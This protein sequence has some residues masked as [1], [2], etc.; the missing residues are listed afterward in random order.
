VAR[1]T[2]LPGDEYRLLSEKFDEM[3]RKYQDITQKIRYLERKNQVVMQKNKDMKESVRAWQEY[4]DRTSGKIKSR[5]DTAAKDRF[6]RPMTAPQVDD[7]RPTVSHSPVSAD[8]EQL[9]HPPTDVGGSSPSPV[10][11]PA[12]TGAGNSRRSKLPETPSNNSR[13]SSSGSITPKPASTTERTN[14]HAS[15]SSHV[16]PFSRTAIYLE[17]EHRAHSESYGAPPTSSQ[18]TVDE[19]PE[20]PTHTGGIDDDDD[21]PQFVS[22][23]SLKRKRGPSSKFAIYTDRSADGTP[24]KPVRVKDEPP[25][26]PPCAA[27]TL[28]RKETIDLDEP[29][30][31]LLLTPRHRKSGLSIHSNSTGISRHQRSN[32]APFSQ[33]L[34]NE[35]YQDFQRPPDGLSYIQTRLQTAADLRA[36]SEP[37]DPSL[38]STDILRVIDSNIILDSTEEVSSKRQKQGSSRRHSKHATLAESGNESPMDENRTR[39]SSNPARARFNQRQRA[40]KNPQT[41]AKMLHPTSTSAPAKIKLEQMPTPPSSSRPTYTPSRGSGLRSGM[42]HAC[43]NPPDEPATDNR[44]TWSM[45]APEKRTNPRRELAA[46]SERQTPLRT[47]PLQELRIQDFRPNPAFNQGYSYAFSET[48]RK[49][50]DRMCLPGCTNAQCCG[51]TFRVLAEAQAPLPPSQEEALLEDYLGDAYDHMVS[52]QMAAEERAELVLQARTKKMAKENGKH[53]EAYERRRT[54]PGFWR[55]DFPTTQEQVE[56]R[57]RAKELE[58]KAVEERW[59]DAQRKGGRWIFR[60]E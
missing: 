7:N 54:P 59:L 2:T 45:K 58:A 52:T 42:S 20:Q 14:S 32:S 56:D 12:D 49:R 36:F 55:V 40:A 57:A 51:S 37:F 9:P 6:S 5:G 28:L 31:N 41:P 13:P 30:P 22:E 18:T 26:S 19:H 8:T 23:H 46:S 11:L 44:P 15:G 60:D 1:A 10:A 29:A 4:A 25:S 35:D 38:S 3:K 16:N 33:S 34:R 53:R 24:A 21:I 39:T 50:G 48:V 17:N 27:H 43:S 47:K